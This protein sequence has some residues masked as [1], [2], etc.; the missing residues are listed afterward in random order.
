MLT[1]QSWKNQKK[2]ITIMFI[3]A[4]NVNNFNKCE[5]DKIKIAVCVNEKYVY[6][7]KCIDRILQ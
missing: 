6:L 3:I 5:L 1:I 4:E 2:S 7:I